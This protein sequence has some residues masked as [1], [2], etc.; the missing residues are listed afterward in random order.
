MRISNRSTLAVVSIAVISLIA[1]CG[2]DD[3]GPTTANTSVVADPGVDESSESQGSLP[4]A[5]EAEASSESVSATVAPAGVLRVGEFAP[6]ATF[7]PAGAQTA[8]SAY[9]AAVYDTLTRQNAS[10]ELEPHLATSWEAL[11]ANTWQ[12]ILRDDVTFHDGTPF[13]AEAVKANLDRQKSAEGN[14]NTAVFAPIS[15]VTVVD[16]Y[17][18]DVAFGVPAPAFPLEMSMVMGMMA[19]PAALDT[20]MTRAPAGSGPWIWNGADSQAG[21]V[22][23][24]DVNPDYWAP[25]LQGVEHIEVYTIADNNARVNALLAGDIDMAATVRDAQF[26]QAKEAG[27]NVSSTAAVMPY[28]LIADRNGDRFEPLGNPLVREAIGYAL[29]RGAYIDAVHAGLG[30]SVG[31]FYG[32]NFTEWH[33]PDLDNAFDYDPDRARELLAE[34]GYPDGFTIE[35]P[36]MPPIST[37]VEAFA[38]MLGQVGITVEQ[39]QIPA[40]AIGGYVRGGEAAI[41]W[42]RALLYYPGKTFGDFTGPAL[43]P[44]GLDDVADLEAM[45]AEANST[46]DVEERKAIFD[47]VGA[48]LLNRGVA[49]PMGHAGQNAAWGSHVTG[50]VVLGLNMQAPLYYTVR[51]DG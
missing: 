24:F 32:P 42:Y 6:A 30:D 5:V 45:I 25:E 44:F 1:A 37:A 49:F 9:L 22:E 12:F 17:T 26:A 38:Q 34:A 7:D 40:G 31:G 18:V 4:T 50:D 27:M 2:T 29:D 46:L 47:E 35:M 11:D 36:V 13:D 39:V 21:V 16:P 14:P 51:V 23:K 33:N 3:A 19:S 20:D 15:K 10:F 28:L 41:T 43:N 8:Q 48:E